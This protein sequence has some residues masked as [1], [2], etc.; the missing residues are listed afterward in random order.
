MI[1]WSLVQPSKMVFEIMTLA[2]LPACDKNYV[3]L[4]RRNLPCTAL[5]YRRG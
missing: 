4:P 5:I 3:H 1:S 2:Y